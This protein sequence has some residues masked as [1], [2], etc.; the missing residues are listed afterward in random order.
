[1][2]LGANPPLA[3]QPVEP[4]TGPT[5]LLLPEPLHRAADGRWSQP[6]RLLHSALDV[7][8]TVATGLAV[9]D[10]AVW[11]P[12]QHAA[13]HALV[14]HLAQRTRLDQRRVGLAL[15]LVF[16]PVAA[17]ELMAQMNGNG[18][19]KGWMSRSPCL[20]VRPARNVRRGNTG[21]PNLYVSR[22]GYARV[23]VGRAPIQKRGRT[24]GTLTPLRV[25]AH[26]MVLWL[27]GSPP[28]NVPT[29]RVDKHR[30]G[31]Q[32]LHAMH[33]CHNPACVNVRHLRWGTASQNRNGMPRNDDERNMLVATCPRT[34]NAVVEPGIAAGF[35]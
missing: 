3:T 27:L 17:P 18:S 14:A 24:R 2:R 28:Q 8:A 20:V 9:Q 25:A 30:S 22:G 16:P 13:W 33:M 34:M 6:G 1:M 26:R 19:C 5:R 21:T 12:G 10:R 11:A 15:L 29:H 23:A 35:G 4:G 32:R 7:L 31:M